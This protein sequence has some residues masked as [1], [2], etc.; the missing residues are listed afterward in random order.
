MEDFLNNDPTKIKWTSSLTKHLSNKKVGKLEETR[1]VTSLYRPFT[2]QYLYFDSMLIHRVGQLPRIFPDENTVNRVICVSGIG[3]RSF[4]VIITDLIPCLDN[5]E[6]GQ[7][8]PLFLYEK[9]KSEKGS[10]TSFLDE[11]SGGP[12]H[13]RHDAL[14]DEGL[15]HFQQAY[16]GDEI[17]KEDVFYYIYGLLHSTDYRE[18]YADNLSKELPKI[19]CVKK[20]EDFW[21]FSKAGRDLVELHLNYETVDMFPAKV[22]GDDSKLSPE[23][24]RVVQMQYGK[25][26]VD[27][28]NVKDLSTIH[29]NARITVSGIPEEAYEYVLNGKSAIDWVMERQSV[30]MDKDSGI[31]ND[32]NDWAIETMQN[33]RYPLELLLR[34]I[35]VSLETMKIVKALP[36]LEID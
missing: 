24:Y 14:T 27:G 30:K 10:Q 33:T 31:P 6:K 20:V 35:T 11:P 9:E 36:G 23:A 18:R 28:K 2:K 32:A 13:T 5:I 4:S 22:E 7:C 17:S 34:V 26:N 12:T 29:Y 8:F 19:P 3:A 21:T 25:K 15:A 1:V 16:P